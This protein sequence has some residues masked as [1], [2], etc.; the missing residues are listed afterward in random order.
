MADVVGCPLAWPP[1]TSGPAGVAAR[2]GG[3]TPAVGSGRPTAISRCWPPGR[4]AV[5]AL[6]LAA[7]GGGSGPSPAQILGRLTT[8]WTRHDWRR[9]PQSSTGRRRIRDCGPGADRRSRGFGGHPRP[10]RS[11]SKGSTAQATITSRYVFGGIGPWTVT[12]PVAL[13]R[14]KSTGWSGGRRRSSP[15]AWPAGNGC[16]RRSTGHR[17]P[18]IL[19]AGGAPLTAQQNVVRSVS[20]DRGSRTSRPCRP[21]WSPPG[22]PPPRSARRS[23]AATAHP[24]YF[25][26]VFQL[27]EQPAST[28]LGGQSSV[29]YR[30]P[31]PY[32]KPPRPA[33]P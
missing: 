27:T 1:C 20:R 11:T 29:L 33:G 19:G 25:E 6:G 12:T 9:W 8:A 13:I 7:C 23:A 10:G 32:S 5:V 30:P 15:R 3:R 26:P 28:Q 21:P 4:R 24:T 18:P 17:G 31:G 16:R 14:R 2:R 22:R